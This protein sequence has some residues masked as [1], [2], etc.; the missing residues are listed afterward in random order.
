MVFSE[1]PARRTQY[2]EQLS[3]SGT[4]PV[5]P[6]CIAGN[7]HRVCCIN[8]RGYGCDNLLSQRSP[9][10]H[11][12]SYIPHKISSQL[13]SEPVAVLLS[14][15]G[16]LWHLYPILLDTLPAKSLNAWALELVRG[17]TGAKLRKA[18]VLPSSCLD[19]LLPLVSLGSWSLVASSERFVRRPIAASVA[20][21]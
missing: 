10:L 2:T 11:S 18:F 19:T 15:Q 5:F 21:R 12:P 7:N 16:G 20:A 3:T 1:A 14:W 17:P 9:T 8:G 6:S 13:S 4:G